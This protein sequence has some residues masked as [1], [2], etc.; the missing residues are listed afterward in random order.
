MELDFGH[1]DERD[2]ASR[3]MRG[4]RMNGLPSPTHS[5]HCS[6]YRTRTLQALSNE[7]KAKKVRFYRNGD[8]YFKGIV[9]AV[10]SDRFRS[11]DALLAD[12]TRSL[13]DNINLPQGV[14]Y[15][16]TIDGSRKIGSMDEL[17][18]GESYVC[19]SDNFFKKVEY[20]KNVNPNWSVNVKT[21]ANQK[22][23]QSLASSNSAQAKENKDFVRPKLVTIIRSGVKPRKA[24]RVLLNKKTAHSFEQV[25]T[26]I[27]EAIKLE[28]GV[29]KK[30]YTLDGK[31]INYA[32]CHAVIKQVNRNSEYSQ[33]TDE[34]HANVDKLIYEYTKG[35]AVKLQ[36]TKCY[37]L[38]DIKKLKF[39]T[40]GDLGKCL[41]VILSYIVA[42]TSL[43]SIREDVK[44]RISIPKVRTRHV[45]LR[46]NRSVSLE[47]SGKAASI[48]ICSSISVTCLHDFFGDDDVFIACGPEKFRY[49]QDDFSLDESEC[50]VMKGSPAAATG[51]KSSPTPQKSSAKSPA[52]MRRSKSPADSGNHQ[53]ANGTSSS[54]LSTPKSKQ[55]PIST[56]TSPGSLRKHKV[57]RFLYLTTSV[58]S[59]VCSDVYIIQAMAFFSGSKTPYVETV[60]NLAHY[61]KGWALAMVNNESLACS[62]LWSY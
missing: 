30:L 8:R 18:E 62:F 56:P 23:P 52:P 28:T 15:I 17:E 33:F 59:V 10:S 43:I 54:Q 46:Q 40:L 25:L 42:E 38:K 4:S 24:V 41:E 34:M 51:S 14:R 29:V 60:E 3:N 19:S 53:D 49:A 36:T 26:D 1:F 20:T 48:D 45:H 7:K 39:S 9:Y 47:H 16:Y 2:K 32:R 22:A 11:F 6:F 27:T 50:R 35:S 37:C 31:Q 21:S 44:A 12:L 57:L 58:S 13:S 61:S 5:A 55:S